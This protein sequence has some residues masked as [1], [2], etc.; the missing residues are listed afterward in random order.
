MIISPTQDHR[1]NVMLESFKQ[2]LSNI[3]S[4]DG[5]LQGKIEFIFVFYH[6]PAVIPL[7]WRFSRTIPVPALSID[8]NAVR[9]EILL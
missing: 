3:V 9:R 2:L 4:A 5:V 8:M 1:N 6:V 7:F